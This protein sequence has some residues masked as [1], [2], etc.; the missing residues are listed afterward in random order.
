MKTLIFGLA[1]AATAGFAAEATKPTLTLESNYGQ[2]LRLIA[3][4]QSAM[5]NGRNVLRMVEDGADM[6]AARI[7]EM[8]A[9]LQAVKVVADELGTESGRRVTAGVELLQERD[10]LQSRFT[11]LEGA[12]KDERALLAGATKTVQALLDA[13]DKSGRIAERRLAESDASSLKS[14]AEQIRL[15][16]DRLV[17]T[18]LRVQFETAL[19][20][21]FQP[22]V[23]AEEADIKKL[24]D[25]Q[26]ELVR[27]VATQRAN[28]DQLTDSLT[29]GRQRM[30]E[31][32]NAFGQS[33]EAFRLVQVAVLRRWLTD[34]PPVGDI[35]SLTI[36]DVLTA[37]IE[38]RYPKRPDPS[39]TILGPANEGLMSRGAS[40][41]MAPQDVSDLNQG[42]DTAQISDGVIQLHKQAQWY[43][44]ML[45]RL[46][47][48][49][50][51]SL[52]EANSWVDQA[53]VWRNEASWAGRTLADQRGTLT[54]LGLDQG[55]VATTVTLIETQAKM[56]REQVD[57]IVVQIDEQIAQLNAITADLETAAAKTSG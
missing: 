12:L 4:T 25:E 52:N 22:R 39:S 13:T 26:Q 46:T 10:R 38:I 45:W 14:V 21:G 43:L 50:Q 28:I 15:A 51:Q 34:G 8:E 42:L 27:Q 54:A 40:G 49:T 17:Q 57:K 32:R 23:A 36:D 55:M 29:A 20:Q 47:T 18:Q 3:K 37:G 41:G 11:A 56:A 9:K 19:L 35:P 30:A 44:A 33:V 6:Q 7:A 2:A 24:R 16:Q 5:E 48:F 53:A 1:L 31:R